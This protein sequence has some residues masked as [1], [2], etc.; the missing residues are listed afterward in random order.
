M[1]ALGKGQSLA[2]R[3]ASGEGQHGAHPLQL[4][5]AQAGRVILKTSHLLARL[6]LT[7]TT[8]ACYPTSSSGSEP[9]LPL[10][11]PRGPTGSNEM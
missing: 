7:A 4:P 6:T 11:N 8:R 9:S 3:E 1:L 5:A 2:G 10:K